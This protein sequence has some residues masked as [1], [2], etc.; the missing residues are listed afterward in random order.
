MGCEVFISY[1]SSEKQNADQVKEVIEANGYS[2]WMAP[3]SIPGGSSYADEIEAAIRDCK[4]M[5]VVL[6]EKA[7]DSIWIPKEISRALDNR[8]IVVPFHIDQSDLRDSFRFYLTDAQRIE[9]YNRLM[10]AYA[11]LIEVLDRIFGRPKEI[12]HEKKNQDLYIVEQGKLIRY[13]GHE[14]QITVPSGIS[15]IGKKAFAGNKEL[16]GITIPD[17]VTRIEE[18][19]FYRCENLESVV[20]PQTL[21]TIQGNVFGYCSSLTAIDIP[22]SVHTVHDLAF[23]CCACLEELFIP[24]G[25]SHF[26]RS[27]LNGCSSL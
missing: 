13:L 4:V 1:T 2:C 7:Q 17:T 18:E 25:V 6:S 19:A 12:S 8:K 3:E 26:S 11:Q 27:A 24:S 5:V 9:A 15:V 21:L 16:H 14:T 22:Q 10:E 20:L 23:N